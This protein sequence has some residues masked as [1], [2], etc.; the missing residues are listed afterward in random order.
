M[1]PGKLGA[2]TVSSPV[3]IEPSP[4]AARF[5]LRLGFR[6]LKSRLGSRRD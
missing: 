3:K 5:A 6:S 4:V 2:T 1:P